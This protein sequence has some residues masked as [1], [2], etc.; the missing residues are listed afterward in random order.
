MGPSI[1][2][3]FLVVDAWA[4]R[5]DAS[6]NDFSLEAMIAHERGHQLLCRHERL[7]RSLP[8]PMSPVTE[9]VLASVVGAL[10]CP[11]HRDGEMFVLKAIGDLVQR[12]MSLAEASQRVKD[13]LVYLEMTL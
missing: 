13:A 6:G 3:D 10:V 8:K 5:R 12:G 7:R 4:F 1:E 11:R 2:H 9:E